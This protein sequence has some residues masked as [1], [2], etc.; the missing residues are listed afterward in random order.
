VGAA[1]LTLTHVSELVFYVIVLYE[2]EWERVLV[3]T[4]DSTTPAILN[5]SDA[6]IPPEIATEHLPLFRRGCWLSGC[7]I[8]ASAHEKAEW[9]QSF[10][11]EELEAWNLNL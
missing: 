8:E 3:C 11:Q 5:G 10:T 6:N 1:P 9:M 2:Q 4:L 7:A